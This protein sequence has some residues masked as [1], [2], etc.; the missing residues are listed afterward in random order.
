MH[1]CTRFGEP[2]TIAFT[3]LTL[4]F[5]VRLERRWEWDT[6]MP[7]ETDL[8][9]YSHFAMGAPPLLRVELLNGHNKKDYTIA[10]N[11]MQGFF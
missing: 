6:L 5:Q 8:P 4:G 10:E 7:N 3:R 2:L 9:Q 11:K 1:A